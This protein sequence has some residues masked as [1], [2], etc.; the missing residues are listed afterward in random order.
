M[1]G[2]LDPSAFAFVPQL[3][4]AYPELLRE[5]LALG[6]AGFVE[7]PDSLTQ[8]ADGYDE[9][10]WLY[11]ALVDGSEA[12]RNRLLRPRAARAADAVPRLVNAGLSLFR[13]G[14]HLYPHRGERDGVLRCHLPI[15]VPAGD[16]GLSLGGATHR[17]QAGR[18][19]IFDDTR[20]HEAWNHGDGDR[21]VL[22]ATFEP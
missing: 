22:I 10:G 15:L 3:E 13:P 19:L 11:C 12:D 21:V 17:W 14:T 2:F 1:T 8:V 16:L 5:Q 6:D 4:A 7:S 9:T 20:E 18:C